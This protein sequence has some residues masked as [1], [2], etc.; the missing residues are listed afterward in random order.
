MQFISSTR[1]EIHYYNTLIPGNTF[2]HVHR[3]P[4]KCITYS[5][6]VVPLKKGQTIHIPR[7]NIKIK[8]IINIVTHRT[9][10]VF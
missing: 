9:V 1:A 10:L 5:S 3:Y 7:L 4:S 8:I 6:A 2:S